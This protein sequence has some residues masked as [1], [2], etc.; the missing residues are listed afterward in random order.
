MP[1]PHGSTTVGNCNA[2][3]LLI[4]RFRELRSPLAMLTWGDGSQ[5][6]VALFL[7]A[8]KRI[9]GDQANRFAV[10]RESRR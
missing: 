5:G 4:A 10:L 3:F 1:R 8:L 2:L 6:E 7:W 9:S